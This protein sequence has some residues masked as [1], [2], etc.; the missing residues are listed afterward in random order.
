MYTHT[1]VHTHT[2]THTDTHTRT[3][4]HVHLLIVFLL[5]L[6]QLYPQ[7]H[8]SGVSA[9]GFPLILEQKAVHVQDRSKGKL[10]VD[11]LHFLTRVIEL[12]SRQL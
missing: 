6:F 3:H 11:L 9:K 7:L 4:T 1:H 2:H 10:V 5:Q 8:F 12:K